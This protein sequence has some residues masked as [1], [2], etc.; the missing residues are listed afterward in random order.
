[1]ITEFLIQ[2]PD[3]QLDEMESIETMFLK[4]SSDSTDLVLNRLNSSSFSLLPTAFTSVASISVASTS[5][6]PTRGC[7]SSVYNYFYF[8]CYGLI[9]CSCL[10][11]NPFELRKLTCDRIL[12]F[13]LLSSNILS[14]LR[15]ITSLCDR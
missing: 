8:W 11:H 10:H 7:I 3:F 6:P 5:S 2:L 1:M 9:I 13:F 14:S 12:K 4:S 15:P